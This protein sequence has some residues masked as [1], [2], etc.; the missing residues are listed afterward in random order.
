MKKLT[1][2]VIA[3]FI[4]LMVFS[5]E[6]VFKYKF[7]A[8]TMSIWDKEKSEYEDTDANGGGGVVILNTET[9]LMRFYTD[10]SQFKFYLSNQSDFENGIVC[11]A[12]TGGGDEGT[13]FLF[14]EDDGTVSMIRAMV[15]KYLFT[16]HINN[17]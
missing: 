3:L 14:V 12:V 1:V 7:H 16:Y 10:A 11:D 8:V 17:K 13:V 9:N 6:N 15:G 4:G 5:Q 2:T